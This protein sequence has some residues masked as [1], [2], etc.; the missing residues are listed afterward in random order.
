MLKTF[1]FFML[2]TLLGIIGCGA[3]EDKVEVMEDMQ[4]NFLSA[5]PPSGTAIGAAATIT[6]TFDGVPSEVT[7]NRGNFE[8]IENRIVVGPLYT[9]GEVE[10]VV[11][12]ADGTQKLLY[13]LTA[14][15]ADPEVA[16]Q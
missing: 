13:Y 8:I 5:T 11:T 7:I 15:C 3:D 9:V 4:V 2:L 16:C 6:I 14:P 10:L 1:T 12:W